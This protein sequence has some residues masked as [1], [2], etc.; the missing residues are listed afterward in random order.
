[1][2]NEDVVPACTAELAVGLTI[3]AGFAIGRAVGAGGVAFGGAE[4]GVDRVVVLTTGAVV[5]GAGGFAAFAVGAV[6]ASDFAT[7]AAFGLASDG[8]PDEAAEGSFA[9]ASFFSL[10]LA[11]GFLA[12]FSVP[13]SGALGFLGFFWER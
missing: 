9:A 10:F 6:V 5:A 8:G 7:A 3:G 4:I 1:M 11:R 12:G 13:S 2:V